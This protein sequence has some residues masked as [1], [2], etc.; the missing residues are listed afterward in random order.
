MVTYG[1]E[2]LSNKRMNVV[3]IIRTI[4]RTSMQRMIRGSDIL[5]YPRTPTLFAS[6]QA[7]RNLLL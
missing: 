7:G 1:L 2:V 3:F 4:L 6:A 5:L